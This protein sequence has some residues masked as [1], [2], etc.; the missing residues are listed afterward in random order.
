MSRVAVIGAGAWGATLAVLLAEKGNEVTL[1]AY[2][3]ATFLPAI[4]VPKDV[5]I[6]GD[7]SHIKDAEIVYFVVPTQFIGGVAEQAKSFINP[8]A[9]VVSA[10]KG[11]EE[12]SLKLPVE[13]LEEKLGKREYAVISGPNLSSEIAKGLPAAAVVAAKYKNVAEKIQASLIQERFRVY[14]NND[15][16]GV[17]LGGA[18]KNVVAIAAGV[19]DG[20]GLGDNAKAAL[21]IRGIVE[22]TRLGVSCGAKPETFAGLSGMGDLITTCASKL[23][24]NHFVGEELAKGKKLPDILKGMKDVAEGVATTRAARELAKKQGIEMPITAQVYSLLYE[25][26]EPYSAI[27]DLMTRAATKE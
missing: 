8:A 16:V 22:I 12:K 23:S 26:K 5:S 24:R 10:A 13:I 19:V 14:T 18:L 15:V 11:I 2:E 1:W 17:E 9:I 20:L 4:P 7:L 6:V 27:S 21:L 25:G 3:G